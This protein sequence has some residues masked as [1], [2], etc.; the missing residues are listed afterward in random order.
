MS[1]FKDR[2]KEE[3]AKRDTFEKLGLN[4][5][6]QSSV[7]DGIIQGIEMTSKMIIEYYEK[8][9]IQSMSKKEIEYLLDGYK[10]IVKK[11]FA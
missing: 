7:N 5:V 4:N 1:K 8:S 11:H 3:K 2:I 6:M 10:E 9:Q